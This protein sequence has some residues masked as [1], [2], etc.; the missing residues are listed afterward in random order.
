[1]QIE[2]IPLDKLLAHPANANVMDRQTLGKLRRHIG[3]SGY[4]EP[5]VVRPHPR[6]A[7]YYELINGHHRRRVLQELGHSAVNCVVWPVS[8]EEALMLLATLNRLAGRDNPVRRGRLLEQLAARFSAKELLAHLPEKRRQMEKLLRLTRPPQVLPPGEL[9]E[10]PQAM[11][12][13][14][15]LDQKNLIENALAVA[16]RHLAAKVKKEITRGEKL[17]LIAETFV[18]VCR[19]QE[20]NH[21]AD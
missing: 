10:L 17:T 1:M 8:D 9:S 13:F 14:V 19:R 3:R 21:H 20:E 4:Y 12:F 5:L 16:G 2:T 18:T 7:S 6:Q 11:N 15:S